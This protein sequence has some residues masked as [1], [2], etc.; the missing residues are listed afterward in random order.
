MILVDELPETL[1][2]IGQPGGRLGRKVEH[3]DRSRAFAVEGFAPHLLMSVDWPRRSPILYQG[4]MGSCTGNAIAGAVATDSMNRM[5]NPAVDEAMAVDL[6]E[7]ATWLDHF[8]GHMPPDDT[9]SSGLAV[10][11]A[12]QRRKL[13]T[14]YRHAF[15]F[16]AVLSALQKGPVIVG[17]TWLTGCD[18]PDMNGV[19]DYSGTIRGGHEF[20]VRGCDM[21]GKLLLGDNSWGLGW[22]L[23]GRFKI[24]FDS[25]QTAMALQADVT[26]PVWA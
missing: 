24:P 26:I 13:I 5:G 21:V 18:T 1:P 22:G 23:N 11:K 2:L 7:L 16:N 25:F 17:M 8:P 3:D 4:G 19:I 6:Y 9:G 10:C 15:S 12:A 20:L 14:S